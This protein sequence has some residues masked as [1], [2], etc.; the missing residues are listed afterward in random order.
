M[1]SQIFPLWLL[2]TVAAAIAVLAFGAGQIV[3]GLGMI[4]A[5]AGG[6]IWTAYVVARTR[7][8]RANG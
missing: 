8:G 7:G 5:A 6:T 3:R 4:V 2:I 1:P